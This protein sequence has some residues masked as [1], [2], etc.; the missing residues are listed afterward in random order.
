MSAII[1]LVVLGAGLGLVI[2]IVVH[3]YGTETDPRVEAIE[4]LLPSAN[5]GACGFAG[6]ADFARSLVENDGDPTQCPSVSSEAVKRIAA[7]LGVSVGERT[8]NVAVVMCGGDDEVASR[9]A[10]YN[11]VYD[12]ND[13]VLVAGGA[14]GCAHGCLGLGSCA[15][16]CP[17]GA[18]EITASGLAV[19]HPDLCTGCGTCVAACPRN[20]IK[21]VPKDAPVHVLCS[22]PAKGGD[23]RKVCKVACIGCR[24][25]VKEANEGQMIM[26][27]FLARVNYEDPPDAS[28]AEVCPTTCLRAFP[29]VTEPAGETVEEQEVV[30]A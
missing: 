15:R 10:Y 23:K 12:C 28:I 5:C 9:A 14:K 22:S 19:V 26:D 20:L 21:L 13:A 11:G 24:K 6:C 1:V 16:A 25:C 7:L 4:G 8:R 27:G 30:H 18:I 17:F 3:Y 2:G 29:A